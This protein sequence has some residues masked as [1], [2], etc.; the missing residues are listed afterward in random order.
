[1]KRIAVIHI[2]IPPGIRR[3]WE[4]IIPHYATRAEWLEPINK[5]HGKTS[6][7]CHVDAD[8]TGEYEAF[9]ALLSAHGLRY[10]DDIGAPGDEER[11]QAVLNSDG[12]TWGIARIEHLY[13]DD[14][15]RASPLLKFSVDRKEIPCPGPRYGTTYD[16]SQACPSCGTGAVQVS[17][18][19]IPAKSL[20]SSGLLCSTTRGEKFVAAPLMET[21]EAAHVTG[22]ELRQ[23]LSHRDRTPLQWWQIIATFEMPKVSKASI[24]LGRDTSR[25][26]GCSICERDMHVCTKLGEIDLVY[27]LRVIDLAAL[28]DMVHTWE[29]FG[30]SVLH[31]DPARH[32][33]RGF[34]YPLTLVKPRIF[35]IFRGLKVKYARFAPVRIEG[36]EHGPS[37]LATK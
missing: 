21:L 6:V 19:Y 20:P 26:W 18:H 36:G 34:A 23:V 14:E 9:T 31:D 8:N 11:F 37:V 30:R 4:E 32:L 27:D 29:C 12:L 13:T 22:L 5:A 17:P 3:Q 33:V 2:S 15:L 35:D 16:M 7:Y 10:P 25:G 1:M 24:N 28:P